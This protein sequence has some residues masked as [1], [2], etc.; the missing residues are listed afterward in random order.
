MNCSSRS[1]F[2][3]REPEGAVTADTGVSISSMY[4]LAS[5]NAARGWMRVTSLEDLGTLDEPHLSAHP[6]GHCD[7]PVSAQHF[8]AVAGLLGFF[9][10]AHV[11]PTT[12]TRVNA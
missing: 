4:S 1:P 6:C 8:G 11:R 5:K 3:V 10:S 7:A 2:F 9:S 12:R